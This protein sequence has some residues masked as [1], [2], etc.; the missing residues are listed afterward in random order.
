MSH[1]LKWIKKEFIE[2][3]PAIVFFF[4]AFNLICLTEAIML[5]ES[6]IRYT[7]FLGATLGALV[8]GKVLLLMDLLPFIVLFRDKPLLFIVVWK[9]ALYSLGSLAFRVIEHIV[10]DVLK[11][12]SLAA[13]F[14]HFVQTIE[15]DRFLAIQIWITVILFIFV[16]SKELILAV[17]PA[18]VRQLFIGR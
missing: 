2:V 16:A 6:G 1:V 12:K 8:T 18:R 13:G 3:L 4:L 10:D 7:S 15:W 17:D 9:T 5:E 11:E 14:N